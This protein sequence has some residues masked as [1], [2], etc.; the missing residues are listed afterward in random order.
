LSRDVE[1]RDATSLSVRMIAGVSGWSAVA[2]L[3]LI[4]SD[5]PQPIIDRS[6]FLS[7]MI[8]SDPLGT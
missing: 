2:I 8:S 1:K 7:V 5:S 6:W 4:I 3:E